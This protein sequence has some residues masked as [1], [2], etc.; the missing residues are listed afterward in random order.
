MT[1]AWQPRGESFWPNA[2][3]SFALN[4]H[5]NRLQDT[6]RERKTSQ[7]LV[8]LAQDC[9]LRTSF[10]ELLLPSIICNHSHFLSSFTL[11]YISFLP[12]GKAKPILPMDGFGLQGS[13]LLGQRKVT[14]KGKGFKG[15]SN[16]PQVL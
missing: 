5:S 14:M 9:F 15:E 2:K 6:K 11:F 1:A 7:S 13:C 8:Y 3:L 10:I 12:L 4:L 16:T